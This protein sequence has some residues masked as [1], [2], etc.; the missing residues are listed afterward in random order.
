MKLNRMELKKIIYDFNS[1]SNRFIRVP[2]EEYDIVLKRFVEFIDKTSIIYDFVMDCGQPTINIA[3]KINEV[4]GAYGRLRFDFGD[5]DKDEIINIYSLLK[6]MIEND[7]SANIWKPYAHS[8]RYQD[9]AKGFNEQV[10][11]VLV[12]HISG[13]LTKIGIDMGMDENIRYS[14]TVHNGQVNVASDNATINSTQNNGLNT[15]EL[16]KILT[17]VRQ[18]ILSLS[19]DEDKESAQEYIEVIEDELNKPQPKKSLLKTAIAGLQAIKGTVEFGAAVTA[20]FQFIQTI[21]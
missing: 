5:T 17:E 9:W 14:I 8:N 2:Y 13:Y 1:L 16:S 6:Y 12:N 7:Y 18:A 4:A 10:V 20:I 3:E 15:S 19:S 11:L 21:I